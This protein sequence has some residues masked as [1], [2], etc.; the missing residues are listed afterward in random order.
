LHPNPPSAIENFPQNSLRKSRHQQRGEWDESAQ[1]YDAFEK[2][3]DFYGT[4]ADA[5]VRQ[6]AIRRDSKVLEL[7]CGTGSCTLKLARIA[8]MG[9]VV[10]LDFSEGMLSVARTNAAEAG[11][12]NVVFIHGNAGDISQILAGDKF[13]FA[14]CNS[15]FWHFPDPKKVLEGLKVLLDELGEFAL[16]LPTWVEG[17]EEMRE[18]FRAKLKEVLLKRGLAPKDLNQRNQQRVD[19]KT[20]LKDCGF[21]VREVPFKFKVSQESR[22]DW[23]QISVFS[24]N[25]RREWLSSEIDPSVREKVM[26]ELEDWRRSK[27]PRDSSISSWRILVARKS[28]IQLKV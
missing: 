7:A 20:L 4:V 13:D 27:F 19:L 3:W 14:V 22:H 24:T 10:A 5:M 15:A 23:R 2:K 28:S 26:K 1:Q 12:A 21:E 17:N 18:A 16:S 11:V 8:E 9:K 25:E 6:L